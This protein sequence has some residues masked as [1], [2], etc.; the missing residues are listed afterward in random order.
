M[1]VC[2][3]KG[4]DGGGEKKGGR[5]WERKEGSLIIG[6]HMEACTGSNINAEDPQDT[7]NSVE[8]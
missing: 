4:G 1:F 5:G 3:G 8:S 2:V 7:T 6:K